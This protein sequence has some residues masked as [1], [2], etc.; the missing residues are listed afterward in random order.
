MATHP[1]PCP[2]GGAHSLVLRLHPWT[3]SGPKGGQDPPKP[4]RLACQ[5]PTTGPPSLVPSPRLP[6][7][8]FPA[9]PSPERPSP[10]WVAALQ[11]PTR[12]DR[13]LE[14]GPTPPHSKVVSPTQLLCRPGRSQTPRPGFLAQASP[15]AGGSRPADPVMV[16]ASRHTCLLL[17]VSRPTHRS[18]A[19]LCPRAPS[20]AA[21]L[22][23]PP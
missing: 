13:P 7:P 19:I 23:W 20:Q 2:A 11:R 17:A 10:T 12:P 22:E 1:E 4:F 18:W 8:P 14:P 6:G 21:C 15:W 5:P 3:L 16:W 9:P